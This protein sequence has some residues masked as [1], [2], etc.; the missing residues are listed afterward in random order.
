MAASGAKLTLSR[1][2]SDGDA[3]LIPGVA[4]RRTSLSQS[5]S[6]GTSSGVPSGID[7]A[8][9]GAGTVSD[10][11]CGIPVGSAGGG[12]SDGIGDCV[13]D[14]LGSRGGEAIGSA[15]ALNEGRE[16]FAA[17]AFHLRSTGEVAAA[18]PSI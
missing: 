4:E 18:S 10:P 8:S 17:G 5:L 6:G 13:G 1:G 3:R 16:R 9:S 11:G 12:R 2:S 14:G 7:N 15:P